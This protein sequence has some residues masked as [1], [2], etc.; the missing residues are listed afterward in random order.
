MA[1]ISLATRVAEERKQEVGE[2]VGFAVRFMYRLSPATKIK[3]LTD[4]LLL[5]ECLV[6][7]MLSQYSVII[8]D[9]IHERTV[10][11]DVLLGILKTAQAARKKTGK[12]ANPLKL[13]LMSATMNRDALQDY[14]LEYF[15]LKSY[16]IGMCLKSFFCL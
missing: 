6:D 9:E 10:N 11:T 1:A 12:K 13:V 3:F 4:G 8:L 5:R 14:F 7:R 2:T 16:W 15:S